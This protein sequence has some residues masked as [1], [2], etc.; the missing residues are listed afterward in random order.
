MPQELPNKP[1]KL[2][3]LPF[4]HFQNTLCEQRENTLLLDSYI[5]N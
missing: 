3:F 2:H 1:Y 4:N 5:K